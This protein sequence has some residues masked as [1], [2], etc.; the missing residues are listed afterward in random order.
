MVLVQ[1]APGFD[2]VEPVL[3]PLVPG[4]L[5]HP[6]EVV[7]DPA[8]LRVLLAHALEARK[9]ALHFLAHG[10]RHP[11]FLDLAPVLGGHVRVLLAQL[12]LDRVQL[13][14]QQEL[15]L[16]LLHPRLDLVADLVLERG[17]GQDV[18]GPPD[19]LLQADLDVER[20]Q[21]LDLAL[22]R[23][24]RGVSG[25]VGQVA[26][27]V[28]AAHHL[29]HL[30]RAAQ[31]EQVLDQ[32][33]VLAGQ[34]ARLLAVVVHVRR[35]LRHDAQRRSGPTGRAPQGGAVEA[36]Q[37]R[38][39]DVPDPAGVLEPGHGAEIGKAPL[40]T[41][42]QQH[43]AV[44]FAGGGDGRPGLLPLDRDR[45]HHLRQHDAVVEWK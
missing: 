26:R 3:G 39:L 35:R 30:L 24:I 38:D 13:L 21:D 16:A 18:A 37:H 29:D 25:Q 15:A 32:S 1:D 23:K 12:L 42:H 14:P 41:R 45:H 8:L 20:L 11:R 28:D 10:L 4:Q 22:Q 5:Q 17:L 6:V 31:L 9:L 34:D 43:Q 40:H 33:L 19:Q 2:H 27:L 44:A 7:A 36:L